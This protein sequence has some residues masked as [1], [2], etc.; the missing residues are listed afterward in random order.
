MSGLKQEAIHVQLV[1]GDSR[2]TRDCQLPPLQRVTLMCLQFAAPSLLHALRNSC[3]QQEGCT[4]IPPASQSFPPSPS[5]P[6]DCGGL[7]TSAGRDWS[8]RR[9]THS[10]D[11][12]SLPGD[13]QGQT[14]RADYQ[15]Q[16]RALKGADPLRACLRQ[17]GAFCLSDLLHTS[18]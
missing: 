11:S 15:G 9:D 10:T 18:Q 2:A 17:A 4:S 6:L 13:C 1:P 7:S 8:L 5:L 16:E 12:P 3:W 14:T